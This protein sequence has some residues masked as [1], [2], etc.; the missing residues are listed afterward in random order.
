MKK[1]KIDVKKRVFLLIIGL[2][3]F[4]LALAGC[5]PLGTCS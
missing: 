3:L 4:V 1:P 5:C 2:G